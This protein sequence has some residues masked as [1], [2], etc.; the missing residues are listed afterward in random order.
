M[1]NERGNGPAPA[2]RGKAARLDRRFLVENETR[3]SVIIE[4]ADDNKALRGVLRQVQRLRPKE[5]LLIANGTNDLS[6]DIALSHP[7]HNLTT[8]VYSF[9]LGQDVWRAIGAREASG[10]V[11]LFLDASSKIKGEELLP[12]VEACYRGADIAIRK[13]GTARKGKKRTKS[14]QPPSPLSLAKA[15]LNSLLSQPGGKSSMIDL[16]FAMTREAVSLVGSEHL[17][18]PPLA[19]ARAVTNRLTVERIG[20][21]GSTR[22]QA[23]TPEQQRRDIVYLGDHLEAFQYV[24]DQLDDADS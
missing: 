12:Y 21:T 14:K 18:V 17:L 10:D 16:P 7:A 4:V 24:A 2:K 1:R 3:L 23:S 20:Q 13:R 15:Y 22:K 19:Y 8:F 11:L 6:L 9:P 5:M